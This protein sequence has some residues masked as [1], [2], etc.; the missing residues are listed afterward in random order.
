M[1]RYFTLQVNFVESNFSSKKENTRLWFSTSYDPKGMDKMVGQGLVH[2]YYGDGKGKT[3]AAIGL[4]LRCVG[5]GGT[6]VLSQ[7]LKPG[8]SGELHPLRL[9]PG[10]TV[11]SAPFLPTFTN[12]MS[13]EE[14]CQTAELCNQLIR[15]SFRQAEL[16]NMLILD[17]GLD[18]CALELL[19]A[20]DLSTHLSARPK[21]LEVVLTGHSIPMPL[22]SHADYITEM[23]K[24]RHPFDSGTPA[25][26]GIEY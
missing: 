20:Q 9:L 22:E 17:E 6:V 8:T 10:V 15:R 21:K 13:R 5:Q 24:H 12:Q 25:R 3:T 18:A 19:S 4:A 14:L 2:I 7:F 26:E 11:L 23:V 1:V 16:A